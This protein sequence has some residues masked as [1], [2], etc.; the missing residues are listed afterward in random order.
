VA[1]HWLKAAFIEDET[2]NL[3]KVSP[4]LYLGHERYITASKCTVRILERDI[5]GK[6]I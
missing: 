6:K 4:V 5:Y 3:G 1:V 2:L